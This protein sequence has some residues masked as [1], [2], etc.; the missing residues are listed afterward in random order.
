MVG[1]QNGGNREH[2]LKEV[3]IEKKTLT[4]D[5]LAI[6]TMP[7][8]FRVIHLFPEI[9]DDTTYI[10]YSYILYQFWKN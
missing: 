6:F 7:H 10:S 2:L 3:L 8:S 9:L 5:D 4:N 1:S